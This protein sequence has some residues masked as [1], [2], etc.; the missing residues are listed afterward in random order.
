MTIQEMNT[1]KENNKHVKRKGF[2]LFMF[3]FLLAV[4][5]A[6]MIFCGRFLLNDMSESNISFADR[7]R[8]SKETFVSNESSYFGMYYDH[9]K[10]CEYNEDAF[11]F[12]YIPD[13]NL[14]YNLPFTNDDFYKSHTFLGKSSRYGCP[15][16]F[17]TGKEDGKLTLV[18]CKDASGAFT[19]LNDLP[20][21]S[22]IFLY[23]K[24]NI[25]VYNRVFLSDKE[26]GVFDISFE[27][28]SVNKGKPTKVFAKQTSIIKNT[29]N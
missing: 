28:Y 25:Y 22:D 7:K 12:L 13:I 6:I 5:G 19:N 3:I 21:S 16:V 11:G 24:D 29:S 23:T 14:A 9:E 8:M 20:S 2:Y 1:N 17:D 18:G 27:G 10:A 26:D 15:Y 4:L